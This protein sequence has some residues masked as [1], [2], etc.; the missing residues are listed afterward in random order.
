MEKVFFEI[1]SS[2]EIETFLFKKVYLI[3][4]TF[5]GKQQRICCF[6][7]ENFSK[8]FLVFLKQENLFLF[9]KFYLL[10]KI[11]TVPGEL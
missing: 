3:N 8:G 7:N 11:F 1:T 10:N 9:K 4:E 6:K 2:K 5:T